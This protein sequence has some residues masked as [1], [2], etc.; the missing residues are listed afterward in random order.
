M[1]RTDRLDGQLFVIRRAGGLVRIG[2]IA[3][4][5]TYPGFGNDV[6]GPGRIVFDLLPKHADI[7]SQVFHLAAVFRSPHSTQQTHMG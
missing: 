5:V 6:L 3:E 2:G 4:T 7:G 1:K